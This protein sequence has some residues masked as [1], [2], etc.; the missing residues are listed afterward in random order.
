MKPRDPDYVEDVLEAAKLVRQFIGTMDRREF[1]ANRLVQSA[2]FFQILVM[3]EAT[4]RLSPELRE[5]YGDV[6][7]TDI[8]GMRDVLIH[9]YD[10]IELVLA[11]HA[12]AGVVPR[13][14]PRLEDILREIGPS[15]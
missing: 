2:V 3:G 9:G 15:P 10:R 11:W 1:D 8:A 4:K 7:W 12:A 13:L 14:I 6:P 5:H